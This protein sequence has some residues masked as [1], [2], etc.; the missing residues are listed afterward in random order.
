MLTKKILK[1]VCL[2][3][4]F[5]Y[6]VGLKAGLKVHTLEEQ[7]VIDTRGKRQMY[8]S[9]SNRHDLTAYKAGYDI[10]STHTQRFLMVAKLP[11]K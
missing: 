3:P 4:I 11:S 7:C 10:Q 5:N 2:I 9:V 8:Q 1:S 6:E